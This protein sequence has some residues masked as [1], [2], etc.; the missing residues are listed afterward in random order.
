MSHVDG[1]F[2]F[3]VEGE[4]GLCED[5]AVGSLEVG[6]GV[7]DSLGGVVVIFGGVAPEIGENLRFRLMCHFQRWR[8]KR[9]RG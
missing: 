2:D 1:G 3:A 6:F 8:W 7:G 9:M 4:E 5:F